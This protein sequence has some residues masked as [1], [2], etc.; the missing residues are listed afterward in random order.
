[1]NAIL[2]RSAEVDSESHP[3]RVVKALDFLK[4][5]SPSFMLEVIRMFKSVVFEPGEVIVQQ[6]TEGDAMYFMQEGHADCGSMINCLQTLERACRLA[7]WRFCPERNGW[8]QYGLT[9]GVSPC[10]FRSRTLTACAQDT[11][12]LIRGFGLWSSGALRQTRYVYL[13]EVCGP[14]RADNRLLPWG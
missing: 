9:R 14:C 4:N 11:L 10:A 13:R 5:E 8:P 3:W 2:N 6:G 7:K 1:M 12:G